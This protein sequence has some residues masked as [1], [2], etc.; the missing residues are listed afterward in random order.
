MPIPPWCYRLVWWTTQPLLW[1]LFGLRVEGREHVPA[2]GPLLV[3]ANHLNNADPFLLSVA[4]PRPVCYM[5]KIELFRVPVLGW[6][7]RQFGAFPIDRGAADREAIKRALALLAAG[8][9]VGVF[10]EGTRSRTASMSRGLLGLG[11]LVARSEAT[12]L[13][14]GIIGSERLHRP[15]PRPVLTIRI[16]RPMRIE[17]PARG[18][19][20]YQAAVDQVMTEIA[21]LVPEPYRG[22]YA[23]AASE[24]PRGGEV[25]APVNSGAA[26]DGDRGA[27]DDARLGA[28]QPA[29]DG[30]DLGRLDPA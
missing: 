2:S 1:L 10:P 30:R 3:V 9:T 16:G 13:P 29:D 4:V 25:V 18:R 7:I 21:R 28:E 15:W 22:A 6:M 26:V 11:L 24:A 8:H 27:A 23:A 19:P 14:V 5:A 12:V 20:D 17:R